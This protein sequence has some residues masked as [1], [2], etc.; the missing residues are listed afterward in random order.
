MSGERD[1]LYLDHIAES[2]ERITVYI[3]G[4]K[5]LFLVSG[6]IQDAVLRRLPTRAESTQH[7]SPKLKARHAEIP[8]REIA[9]FRHRIVRNYLSG[10]DIELDW[11]YIRRDLP[12]L[13]SVV[14]AE[15]R[16]QD[17]EQSG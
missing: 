11:R 16:R 9:A 8:W 3:A 4:D 15:L 12:A 13:A 17:P 10:F 2:I 5:E 6:V 14:R 1:F 7:L